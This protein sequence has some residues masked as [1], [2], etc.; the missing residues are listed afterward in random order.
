M[1]AAKKPSEEYAR[2]TDAL[3][4]VLSVSHSEMQSRLE[5]DKKARASKPRPS[6]SRASRDKD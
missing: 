1:K 4:R 2:F 5:A 6:S 3:K